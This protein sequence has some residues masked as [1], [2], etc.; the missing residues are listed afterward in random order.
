M[1]YL[2]IKEYKP[3]ITDYAFFTFKGQSI[4]SPVYFG[5]SLSDWYHDYFQY[6]D[7]VLQSRKKILSINSL[8][9]FAIY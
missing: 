9:G 8:V 1:I 3:K 2:G 7:S 6:G 5:Y 4:V